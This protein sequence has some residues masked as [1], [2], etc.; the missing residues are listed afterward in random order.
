M[1]YHFST[2]PL[3]MGIWFLLLFI[4]FIGLFAKPFALT[5]RLF[6]NMTAGH[7]IILSLL[8]INTL[9]TGAPPSGASVR[10]CLRC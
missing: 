5:V 10:V 1:P 9:I 8:F 2:K 3:D 4:E 7:C 6:A